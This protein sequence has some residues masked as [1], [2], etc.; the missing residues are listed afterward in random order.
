MT[1][2]TERVRVWSAGTG[3]NGNRFAPAMSADGRFVAFASDATNLVGRDTNGAVDI[4]VHDRVTGAT[5]RVSVS[6]TGAQANDDSFAG[7]FAPAVSADGRFVAFSSD[8][9]NL[10]PGDTN[11]RTDV[12]VRDRRPTT[13]DAA[14]G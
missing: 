11:G 5:K 14:A 9:T 3:A 8:A 2:P 12:F 1:G 7:F 6:S 13:G 10:V 4:F